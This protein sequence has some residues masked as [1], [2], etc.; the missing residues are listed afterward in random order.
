MSKGHVVLDGNDGTGK[1]TLAVTLRAL[2]YTVDDR[3][4]PTKMTDDAS[5]SPSE[6]DGRKVFVILDVPIEV[7]RARLLAA[8]KDLDEKYHTIEDLTF[9][10]ERYFEVVERLRKALPSNQV[11][12][13]DSS[14]SPSEVLA[15]VLSK[16]ETS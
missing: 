15:V 16:I 13:L 6:E 5:L 11:H 1:S 2:G 8:G 14:G 7:S 10:R 9:Y 12:T 4:I 3:G